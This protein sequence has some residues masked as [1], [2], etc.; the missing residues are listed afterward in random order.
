M[1]IVIILQVTIEWFPKHSPRALMGKKSS[2]S[3]SHSGWLNNPLQKP[4]GFPIEGDKWF[5]SL[6]DAYPTCSQVFRERGWYEY[7][8]NLV[9]H[10]PAVS[11]AFAKSFDGEKVEFKLLTLWVTE[12]SIVEATIF[13]IEGDKWFKRISLKPSDF[14]YLLVREHKELDWRKGIP[15]VWIKKEFRDLLY[16][17]QKYITSEGHFSPTFIYHLW[18][19]SHLVKDQKL[20]LPFYFLKSLTKMDSKCKGLGEISET[21]LFHHDLIKLLVIHVLQKTRQSWDQFLRFE[22]FE[23]S[24]SM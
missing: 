9:G 17:I 20:S 2:L 18:L 3:C 23:A 13:A 21:H 1:S 7:C 14:N 19:L 8:Y 16:L 10:H 4:L 12:Q 24:G 5:T 6:L 15:R 22:G 11:K